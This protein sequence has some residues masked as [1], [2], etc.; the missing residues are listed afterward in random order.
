MKSGAS[1]IYA[2]RLNREW[3]TATECNLDGSGETLEDLICR[4]LNISE[5]DVESRGYVWVGGSGGSGGWW[6]TQNQINNLQDK[7]NNGV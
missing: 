3:R 5:V 2:G 4:A 1:D 6:L 7:I